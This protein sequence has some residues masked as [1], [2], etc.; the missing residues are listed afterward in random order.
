MSGYDA[1][2][3][4]AAPAATKAELQ[5]RSLYMSNPQNFFSLLWASRRV[6][7]STS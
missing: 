1:N 3:L 4:A 2:L 6:T 7:I 5:V